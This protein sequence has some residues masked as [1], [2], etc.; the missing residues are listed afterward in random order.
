MVWLDVRNCLSDPVFDVP[1]GGRPGSTYSRSTTWTAP[2]SGRLVAGGGHLHGG[3]KTIVLSQPDCGGR[4]L[5]TSRP[6]Y[7]LPGGPQYR[8]RPVLH[9]PGPEHMSGF[10]SPAG[11]PVAR[12]QRLSLTANYDNRYPHARVM[13]IMGVYFVPD[14]NVVDGCAPLPPLQEYGST[15]AGRAYPVRFGVPLA[16]KPQGR[17]RRLRDGATI[18]VRDFSFARERAH[19][20]RGATLRWKFDGANLHNVTVASGPRA[21]SS[22]NLNGGRSYRAKLSAPGTYRLH[23]TL[24]P[25][26][27]TQEIKVGRRR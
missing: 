19:V 23:C 25:T 15:A 9:E 12:G 21:F 20:P 17:L 18:R 5:F 14:Q 4:V 22:P 13:G 3:G 10:L 24:H 6:L 11:L 2:V 1:G 7:G 8:A 26:A 27:M 16:R